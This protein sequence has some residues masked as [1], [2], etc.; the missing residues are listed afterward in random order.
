MP[1]KLSVQCSDLGYSD[2]FTDMH[3]NA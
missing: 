2:L 1:S 3:S